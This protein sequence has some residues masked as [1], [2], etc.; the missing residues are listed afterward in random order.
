[1]IEIV[2]Q[3][4]MDGCEREAIIKEKVYGWRHLQTEN[5][6]TF[7]RGRFGFIIDASTSEVSIKKYNY[8]TK[9]YEIVTYEDF[10]KFINIKVNSYKGIN[11][12][13]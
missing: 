9:S 4:I 12:Y 3:P 10:H 6:H 8:K 5:I 1:M 2:F 11:F 7:R 13:E